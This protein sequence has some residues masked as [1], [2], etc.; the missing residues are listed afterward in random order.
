MYKYII[1]RLLYVIPVLIGVT[2]LVFLMIHL[3]PGDPAQTIL[4]GEATK[5][6]LAKLRSQMGLDQPLIIQYFDW[7]KKI[8]TGNLGFSYTLHMNIASE[9]LP[10]FWNSIILTLASLVIAIILGVGSGVLSAIYKGSIFDK[11]FMAISSIG[12]SIPVFWIALMLMWLL[13]LQYPIFPI[14]GMVNMRGNGGPLDLLYHL[15]LPAFATS[16]VSVAVIAQLTRNA[17]LDEIKKDYV[18]FF[19]SFNL[20]KV[21]INIFHVLR[22]ALPPII[23]IIGLQVG[24]IIGGALFSEI[25]FSWPGVGQAMY[26]AISSKDYPMIQAGILLIACG[27]VFVNLIV[28]IINIM[29]NPKLHESVSK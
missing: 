17:V 16:L 12:A 15:V 21:H 10:K 6:A 9:L 8:I 24:Y 23:N 5:S 22:N 1:S 19:K 26:T 20:S 3:I 28:D 27:F 7:L 2:I 14:N 25:V 4:G 18:S 13:A 11:V 29:I